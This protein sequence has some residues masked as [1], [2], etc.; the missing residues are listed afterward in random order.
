MFIRHSTRLPLPAAITSR[1]LPE[2]V[3]QAAGEK[4][5]VG[6]AIGPARVRKRVSLQVGESHRLGQW[7]RIPL[8]WSA[9]PGAGLFPVL[10]G[11]L[12]L[13]PL[14]PRE[15][16]LSLRANYEPPMGRLGKAIDDAALHT[17]ARAT[18]K[19]FVG[20]VRTR[21]LKAAEHAAAEEV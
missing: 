13:E 9:E 17:V 20:A 21:V 16:K 5:R 19:D 3:A 8:T 7:L 15:S 11:F 6:F 12:Q 2:A 10:E 14:S 4:P 18:V 1:V